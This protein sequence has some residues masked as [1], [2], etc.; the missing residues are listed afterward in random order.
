MRFYQ[1]EDRTLSGRGMPWIAEFTEG[2]V[3]MDECTAC[4]GE[5]WIPTGELRAQL[6]AR[7]G[8]QWPDLIGSGHLVGLFVASG[9]F[10]GALSQE[11]V[12]VELGGR[13]KFAEPTPKR[14]S[15]ADAPDYHWVD[16]ARLRAA[17]LDFEASGYVDV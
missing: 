12:R 3:C 1:I 14:L 16:G 10:V 8:T 7:R 5:R 11:C 9:R 17:R 13:V 2:V 4:G 6:D 15:L